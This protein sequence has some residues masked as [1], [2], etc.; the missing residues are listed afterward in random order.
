MENEQRC[1]YISLNDLVR[2]M[3]SKWKLLLLIVLLV[4]CLFCLGHIFKAN[5]IS[6]EQPQYSTHTFFYFESDKLENDKLNAQAILQSDEF[7]ASIIE[8]SDLEIETSDLRGIINFRSEAGSGVLEIYVIDGRKELTE[9]LANQLSTEGLRQI[10]RYVNKKVHLT[11]ITLNA[12][13]VKVLSLENLEIVDWNQYIQDNTSVIELLKKSLLGI[14]LGTFCGVLIILILI[15]FNRKLKYPDEIETVTNYHTLGVIKKSEDLKLNLKSIMPLLLQEKKGVRLAVISCHNGEGKTTFSKALI[16]EFHES[17]KK[18]IV[19]NSELLYYNLEALELNNYLITIDGGG[20]ALDEEALQKNAKKEG[21]FV[22]H[23]ELLQENLLYNF[24]V[25]ILDTK[26]IETA[27]DT[28]MLASLCDR[29]VLILEAGKVK[30]DT[31][32]SVK[33]KLAEF[34]ASVLGVVINKIDEGEF[35]AKEKYFGF[36]IN[37]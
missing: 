30:D 19:I 28:Y 17:R 21:N 13:Q 37:E 16:Q 10:Q 4:G 29:T 11:E 34:N 26:S 1:R 14:I 35:L 3:V 25:I 24:D 2:E 6:N 9:L 22:E 5:K 18:G 33:N 8:K 7:L 27:S 23:F 36:S 15:L 20:Y 12:A 32:K 31:L